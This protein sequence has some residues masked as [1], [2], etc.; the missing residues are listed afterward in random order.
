MEDDQNST[1]SKGPLLF[2][3]FWVIFEKVSISDTTRPLM[4]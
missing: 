4:L 3:Q 1:K 2:G